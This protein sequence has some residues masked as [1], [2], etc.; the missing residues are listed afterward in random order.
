MGK[1]II[2][3]IIG[4]LVLSLLLPSIT[5]TNS[6]SNLAKPE[7]QYK[8]C[9]IVAS[10]LEH[11]DWP[12]VIK[13]PNVVRIMWLKQSNSDVRFGLYSYVLFGKDATVTIYDKE[14]G[15]QVW[16]HQGIHDP[17]ITLVGFSGEYTFNESPGNLT[18]IMI[19]GTA[20]F[21]SIRLCD[22]P[23]YPQ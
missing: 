8:N 22:F 11:S 6:N 10:G 18:Q 2:E 9:Y 5:A 21:L 16:Q 20:R 3:I 1:K 13:L 4:T 12:A 23:D 19:N 15:T 7:G 14:G 17:L